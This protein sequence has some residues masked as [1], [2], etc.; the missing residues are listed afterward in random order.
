MVQQNPSPH[1]HRAF[2]Q[3]E[4]AVKEDKQETEFQK[5]YKYGYDQCRQE[6]RKAVSEKISI[7]SVYSIKTT[8]FSELILA[9]ISAKIMNHVV[10]RSK[11]SKRT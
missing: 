9:L 8:Y 10:N 11:L 4:T 6:N 5:G 3:V 2:F 1:A 7:V